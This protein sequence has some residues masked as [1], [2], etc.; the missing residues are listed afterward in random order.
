MIVDEFEIN[1]S[2]K[3][4]PVLTKRVSHSYLLKDANNLKKLVVPGT[5][6][7]TMLNTMCHFN[8]TKSGKAAMK[9]LHKVADDFKYSGIKQNLAKAIMKAAMMQ[10]IAHEKDERLQKKLK[11]SVD[12]SSNDN[13]SAMS[14]SDLEKD[15][16]ES[17]KNIWQDWKE[18]LNNAQNNNYLPSLSPEK[19]DV[20][21]YGINLRRRSSLPEGLYTRM[22]YETTAIKQYNIS[23]S[24]KEAI[25]NII[26]SV[27]LRSA[28]GNAIEKKALIN[29]FMLLFLL[30]KLPFLCYS[31]EE[32][33]D[34][35]GYTLSKSEACLNINLITP[36]LQICSRMLRNMHYDITY[37]P[38]EVELTSMTEQVRNQG[39]LDSRFKYYAN[40][41]VRIDN[42][43]QE[44]LLLEVSSALDKTTQDE[45][46][47][48]HTK[49][50]FGLLAVLRI[51]ACKYC[52]ESFETFKE[53]KIHFIHVCG[54]RVIFLRRINQ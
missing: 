33:D 35:I 13:R 3:K 2:N 29:F 16:T 23:N 6:A 30:T 9:I 11:T 36:C 40:G 22:R 8:E 24:Y 25:K 42:D 10:V 38:G 47:F 51:L 54:K 15:E 28:E 1:Y 37:V 4:D 43:K 7:E 27:I 50:M 12:T 31:G 20:T 52:Y 21:W 17:R 53:I 32:I 49:A 18:F 44:P 14:R 45:I 34:Y 41:K 26:Q 19:H 48:D 5:I 46:A 39:L